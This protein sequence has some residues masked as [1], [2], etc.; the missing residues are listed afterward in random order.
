MLCSGPWRI[1]YTLLP[2]GKYSFDGRLK[3]DEHC[4]FYIAPVIRMD[5]AWFTYEISLS[6]FHCRQLLRNLFYVLPIHHVFH[7]IFTIKG[8]S[9]IFLFKKWFNTCGYPGIRSVTFGSLL[10]FFNIMSLIVTSL[11]L[12]G[13]VVLH[14][15][16]R[17]KVKI[18]ETKRYY[19]SI[20]RLTQR[21][22]IL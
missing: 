4:E 8:Y 22:K 21:F 16:N 18:L 7:Y 9:I 10:L 1:S 12:F 11:C 15:E 5:T 2:R 17:S 14:F 6:L 19:N 3:S 20:K 13:S